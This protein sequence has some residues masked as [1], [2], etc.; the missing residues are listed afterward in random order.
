MSYTLALEP[1]TAAW[2]GQHRLVLKVD[3]D[4]IADVDYRPAEPAAPTQPERMDVARVLREAGGRCAICAYAHRLA[5]CLALEQ[6]AGVE[7]PARAAYLRSAGAELERAASHLGALTALFAAL[8]M[9][10]VAAALAE[11][12]SQTHALL[13]QIAGKG[14]PREHCVPGGV[15]HNLDPATVSAVRQAVLRLSRQLFQFA[16]RTIDR[17]LILA[18]T[19]EVGVLSRGAA[20]QFRLSGPL[21]RSTGIAADVR[22]DQPYAAY[23]A[24]RPEVITQEGGDVYARMV[25]LALEA[26]ESL[27]LVDRA[28]ADLPAGPWVAR[29]PDPLPAGTGA[30]LVEAPR[31]ALRYTVESD[32]RRLTELRVEAAPQLDRLLARTLITRAHLDNAVLIALS[33]DPC[34]GCLGD[35][36][37]SR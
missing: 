21:A 30:G 14:G 37:D 16:D 24:L 6:L 26:L 22:S 12:Q 18:R 28:L 2:G 15:D 13:A 4:T 17:R 35:I 8:G 19:I 33:T 10:P 32:G 7:P 1:S 5:C 23:A 34:S 3:G 36:T 25:L 31:G 29:M 27:K 9:A 20:E 11:Q